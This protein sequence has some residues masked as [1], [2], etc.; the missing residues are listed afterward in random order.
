VAT[1]VAAEDTR[2]FEHVCQTYLE[3]G[4]DIAL[5]A[6]RLGW[7]VEDVRQI[8]DAIALHVAD[9]MDSPE[10]QRLWRGR[11]M[12]DAAALTQF[13]LERMRTSER[14]GHRWGGLALAGMQ[15]QDRMAALALTK[16]EGAMPNV[17]VV[18]GQV[19]EPMAIEATGDGSF[20]RVLPAN[21]ADT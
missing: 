2:A 3:S 12:L 13:A 5:T 10:G 20:R 6:K 17:I 18:N 4:G 8:R 7:K 19:P 1:N 21:G 14:A 9:Q 15:H 16:G 11:V